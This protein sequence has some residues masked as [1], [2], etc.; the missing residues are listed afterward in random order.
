MNTR[1]KRFKKLSSNRSLTKEK[2]SEKVVELVLPQRCENEEK[3]DKDGAKRQN[4]RHEKWDESIH[5][6]RLVGNLPRNLVSAHGRLVC[7]FSES[8]VVA[9][10]DERERDAEPHA[11]NGDHGCERNRSGGLLAPDEKVEKET[12]AECDTWV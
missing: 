1:I 6:P 9:C 11:Q 7:L 8:E 10:H 4:S 5:V 2:E 3:L 12:G